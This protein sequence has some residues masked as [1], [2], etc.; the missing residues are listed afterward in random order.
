LVK[1]GNIEEC[2]AILEGGLGIL[3]DFVICSIKMKYRIER[4]HEKK[5]KIER[6]KGSL[7]L[8]SKSSHT[9]A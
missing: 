8:P 3:R 1:I 6:G 9:N 7:V 2:P 5:Y 4:N